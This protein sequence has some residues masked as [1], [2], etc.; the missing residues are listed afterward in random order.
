M[1]EA[2]D[3]RAQGQTEEALRLITEALE[4]SPNDAY[5]WE[6]ASFI[7]KDLGQRGRAEE[8]VVKMNDLHPTA[9]GYVRHAQF[10]LMRE[11]FD[12]FEAALELAVELGPDYGGIYIARGDRLAIAG[13]L[14][15]ALA[16]F[17]HALA[18]DP[19]RS[20]AAASQSIARAK[21]FLAR[22]LL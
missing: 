20:G 6:I 3:R 10:L 18:V 17:E 12:E 15:E 16:Q 22:G 13:R 7:Y 2:R 9:E 14:R 11:A 1:V 21:R 8:C 4:V 19:V 5:G